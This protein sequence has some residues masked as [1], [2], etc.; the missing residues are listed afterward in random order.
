MIADFLALLA[1][2]GPFLH[3]CAEYLR[4]FYKLSV[5]CFY[6]SGHSYNGSI[7]T[8]EDVCI[9]THPEFLYLSLLFIFISIPLL[10]SFFRGV[11]VWDTYI[12]V[13]R[14]I[15]NAFFL[16]LI[17]CS[18]VTLYLLALFLIVTWSLGMQFA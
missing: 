1:F 16:A 15:H 8:H 12:E 14:R 7:F 17:E 6:E 5:T 2:A 11:E 9:L 18:A 4:A 3:L 13:L 10:A